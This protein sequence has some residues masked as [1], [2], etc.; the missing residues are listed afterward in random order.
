M[1]ISVKSVVAD[2]E[3]NL[4]KIGFERTGKRTILLNI[5]D[6][7]FGWVGINSGIMANSVAINPHVGVHSKKIMELSAQISGSKYE[8]GKYAT[9]SKYLGTVDRSLPQLIVRDKSDL[10]RALSLFQESMLKYGVP[11]MRQYNNYEALLPV[12]LDNVSRLGG[13]PE[14]VAI[15]YHLMGK[16]STAL[17]FLDDLK[18]SFWEENNN[19]GIQYVDSFHERFHVLVSDC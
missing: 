14:R 17:R 13:Y 16:D 9:I 3:E 1:R 18:D 10:K 15:C 12:L 6:D 11:F 4:L 7:F 5:G 2:F 8:Y 19:Y